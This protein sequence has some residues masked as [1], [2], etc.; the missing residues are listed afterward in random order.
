MVETKRIYL[1]NSEKNVS[2]KISPEKERRIIEAL[3]S[4]EGIK[5]TLQEV[6][7]S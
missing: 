2:V 3:K 5:R 4:L 7:K 1:T 6:L